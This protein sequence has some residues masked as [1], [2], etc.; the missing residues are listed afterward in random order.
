MNYT[1]HIYVS[2][3]ENGN[4]GNKLDAK[5]LDVLCAYISLRCESQDLPNVA[6]ISAQSSFLHLSSTSSDYSQ[7]KQALST[8]RYERNCYILFRCTASCK[9]QNTTWETD[10]VSRKYRK[11]SSDALQTLSHIAINEPC[12]PIKLDALY[13]NNERKRND[14][15][16]TN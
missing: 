16:R 5:S 10:F 8:M 7:C 12:S 11:T 9:W 6:T 3:C 1:E 14:L 15:E 4:A 2:E 13:L